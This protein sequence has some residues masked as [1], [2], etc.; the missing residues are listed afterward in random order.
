MSPHVQLGYQVTSQAAKHA[1]KAINNETNDLEFK[2]F[3]K[4]VDLLTNEGVGNF[5]MGLTP[6]S[7]QTIKDIQN[8]PDLDAKQ[9]S[10]LSV[11]AFL[12]ININV[13]EPK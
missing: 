10:I 1:M 11:A 6:V 5:L 8:S 9:K 7:V 4:N 13:K 3:G 12:G 2:D